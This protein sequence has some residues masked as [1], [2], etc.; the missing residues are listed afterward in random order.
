MSHFFLDLWVWWSRARTVSRSFANGAGNPQLREQFV[1]EM[2][3]IPKREMNVGKVSSHVQTR[4]RQ[5]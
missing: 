1:K 3:S 4:Q 5:D 2:F